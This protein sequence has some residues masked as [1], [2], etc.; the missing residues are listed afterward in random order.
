MCAN[1]NRGGIKFPLIRIGVPWK[2]KSYKMRRSF[3]LVLK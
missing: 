1:G 3:E 2:R